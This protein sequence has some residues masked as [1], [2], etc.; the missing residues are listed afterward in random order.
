MTIASR[1]VIKRAILGAA[2]IGLAIGAAYV[3]RF[4]LIVAMWVSILSS[5]D[6]MDA[7]ATNARGDVASAETNFFGAPEHRV[8]TLIRL[9]RAGHW[10]SSTL[11][12]ARSFDVLVGLKWRNNDTL[13]LQLDF[14]CEPQMERPI[15]QAGPIHIV[16]HW[17]DPGY[18]PKIGYETFRRRD[19]PP[20]PCPAT[21]SGKSM[22]R[23]F[24]GP[25][26]LPT[27]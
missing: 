8:K 25:T 5:R 4:V 9:H 23:A 18:D 7:S 13:D 14:G 17:G 21:T 15:T 2:L 22:G 19:L 20:E 16:Y 11:V 10:F 12:N 26:L 27:P 24:T 3:I 6:L 1:R